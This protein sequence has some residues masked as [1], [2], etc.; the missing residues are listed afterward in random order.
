M[1]RIFCLLLFAALLITGVSAVETLE[2][3]AI[4]IAVPSAILMEKTTGEILYE[5][6]AH[7]RLAPASVTK[8]MT[9]L[10]IAE[11]IDGGT[12]STEELVTCSANAASMGGSQ[13]YLE[14]GEQMS[15]HEMFKAL[16]VSSGNDAAVALAEHIAGSEDAFVSKMN[17][18]A[19][20]LG[21]KDTHFTNC[22]GLFDDDDHYTSAYDI[23]VIS[24]EL[25]SHSMIREYTTIWMD[26]I[27]D[28]TFG[29]ANTNKLIYYYS[30]ATGLKTG[31]TE[32]AMYCLS[33]TAER[34][35]V[36]YIAVVMHGETSTERFDS[37][38][39]LL[40]YA[41]AN[42]ALVSLKT[43]ELLPTIQV[44]LGAQDTVQTI[45]NANSNILLPKA[46]AADVQY[47]VEYTDPIEAPVK[48]GQE[49]GTLTVR[50]GDTVL[51]E[52]SLTAAEDIARLTAPQLFVN[53]LR[54]FCA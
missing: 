17:S 13:V 9:M 29:L 11:A 42:Y 43:E 7:E 24:R 48:A 32:K 30:G 54:S 8:V 6:N 5:K 37:A 36:E 16:V 1:K 23:A 4:N 35:G 50:S 51:A 21:L 10:L 34:D 38:K 49:L 22:T 2:G 20:E 44:E 45:C 31:F 46:E 26:T 28:G 25:I 33:A 27:R 14:E 53:M 12:L 52:L 18:R 41:F 3:D 47:D 15:V 39:T 19:E 40:N